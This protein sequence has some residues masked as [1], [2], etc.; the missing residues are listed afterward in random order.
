MRV[1]LTWFWQTML[2]LTIKRE[3]KQKQCSQQQF[4]MC[5]MTTF[6]NLTIFDSK[7]L[8]GMT[9]PESCIFEQVI[10]DN[11]WSAGP[12]TFDFKI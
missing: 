6:T 5:N 12:L 10:S 8:T 2:V 3:L 7:P 9:L 4:N 1:N 11:I